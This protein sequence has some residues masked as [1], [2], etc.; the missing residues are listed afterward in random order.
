MDEEP[1]AGQAPKTVSEPGDEDFSA[2][3]STAGWVVVGE[4]ATG[5]IGAQRDRDWFAVDLVAGREYRIDLRGSPTDD[6]TLS[7]PRLYG[8]HDAEGNLIAHTT[9][10][11]WGGTYNSRVT[12]TATSSGTHYIAAG[13]YGTN[14]GTYELEVTDKSPG[15]YRLAAGQ[16]DGGRHE[17]SA[18]LRPGELRLRSCGERGREHGPGVAGH[19]AGER[20]RG[21]EPGL[22]PGGCQRFVR[23]RRGHRRTVLHRLGRG[24][25]VRHDPVRIHGAGQRR[26]REPPTPTSRLS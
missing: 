20:P 1:G 21:C 2:D 19:G 22:W 26:E 4:T 5:D 11:D 6:G 7:D 13:A 15:R 3:T 10:D 18:L 12:F 25:R 16:H 23:D 17:R 9:N 24:L 8:I 14:L